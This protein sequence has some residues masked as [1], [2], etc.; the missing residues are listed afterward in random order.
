MSSVDIAKAASMVSTPDSH[1][2]R[3]TEVR[4][5]EAVAAMV[6]TEIVTMLKSLI[7]SQ[8][9]IEAIIERLAISQQHLEA[10]MDQLERTSRQ[11][12]NE[13]YNTV[14]SRSFSTVV[15]YSNLRD[16]VTNRNIDYLQRALQVSGVEDCIDEELLKDVISSADMAVIRCVFASPYITISDSLLIHAI[17]TNKFEIVDY[18]FSLPDV[19]YR[20]VGRKLVYYA[21]LTRN[22]AIAWLVLQLPRAQ[23]FIDDRLLR[24]AVGTKSLD[25]VKLIDDSGWSKYSYSAHIIAEGEE[26]VPEKIAAYI[27][28]LMKP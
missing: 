3:E 7:S 23:T 4:A 2:S 27:R 20:G 16:A 12:L 21:I 11:Q 10:R 13:I 19:P 8:Q 24:D 15:T 14:K 26:P 5:S 22:T 25:I 1:E 17:R 6:Q 9:R 18:L 28:P